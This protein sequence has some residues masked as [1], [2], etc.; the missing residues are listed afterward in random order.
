MRKLCVCFIFVLSLILTNLTLASQRCPK[1][2][3]K[4]GS[5]CEPCPRGSYSSI[6]GATSQRACKVCPR[7]T[8]SSI[9]GATSQSVCK[10][11]PQGN[12]IDNT[13]P[14]ST[15]CIPCRFH[16]YNPNSGPNVPYDPKVKLFVACIACPKGTFTNSTG[17]ANK[18]N[19][20][21]PIAGKCSPGRYRI[22]T[23][24]W[25]K[26]CPY[27][28]AGTYNPSVD[29]S[30]CQPCPKGAYCLE[31][32]AQPTTCPSGT[33]NPINNQKTL[34]AC[35]QCT[36]GTYNPLSGASAC[37]PCP[38]G[39][40]CL[41]G[42][43][44]PTKCPRGTYNPKNNQKTLDAC[45]KCPKGTYNPGIGKESSSACLD[46]PVNEYNPGQ[47][48]SSCR[49]CRSGTYNPDIG[50]TS[51]SACRDCPVNKISNAAAQKNC[52]RKWSSHVT[53]QE[54]RNGSR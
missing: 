19:C 15:T 29:A 35:L 49:S 22:K 53:K 28:Q 41:E 3:Y 40:Y 31:G 44:Q 38:K 24:T 34:A 42:S 18:D 20:I 48:K 7:G 17:H 4:S 1:G 50:K 16:T 14:P 47:G 46:C 52:G 36:A 12:H 30:A 9:K 5:R 25:N 37:Q 11:C 45:L 33:Y 26:D 2:T 13:Y 21:K 8:Y 51:R 43:A 39:S 27:C 6:E 54:K 23:D 32:S 10:V